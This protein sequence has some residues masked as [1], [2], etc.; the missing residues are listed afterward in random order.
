MKI[1]TPIAV[2]ILFLL[3]LLV[4]LVIAES[5]FDLSLV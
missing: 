2:F 1:S 3:F 4:S 5:I